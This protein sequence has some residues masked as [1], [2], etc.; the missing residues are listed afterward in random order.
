MNAHVRDILKIAAGVLLGLMAFCLVSNVL[1]S[2][3]PQSVE[4][5]NARD[6]LERQFAPAH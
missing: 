4:E 5:R 2:L 3:A 1:I 6:L